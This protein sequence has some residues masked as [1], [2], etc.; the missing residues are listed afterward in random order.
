V[1]LVGQFKLADSAT[2]MAPRAAAQVA[3][4]RPVRT[5]PPARKAVT[6]APARKDA[7]EW[8]AF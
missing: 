4:P 5:L 7:E 3:A 8:E 2:R 6:Q 1:E